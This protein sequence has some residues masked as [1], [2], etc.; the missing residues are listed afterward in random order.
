MTAVVEPAV[1]AFGSQPVMLPVIEAKRKF[2]PHGALAQAPG[3]T[4]SVET[5]LAT[6]PVGKPPGIVTVCGLALRT[7]GAPPTSPRMSCA[8]LVP[9]L[10]TQKGLLAVIEMPHGLTMSGSST[11]ARPA[12]SEMRLVCRY[13]EP[14]AIVGTAKFCMRPPSS[15][16]AALAARGGCGRKARTNRKASAVLTDFLARRARDIGRIIPFLLEPNL[17]NSE[18]VSAFGVADGGNSCRAGK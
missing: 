10:A 3:R 17:W 6:V 12:M 16:A 15:T 14:G 9:L 7:T 2:A 13:A 1:G 18:S 4:N 5:G 11:G 8:V